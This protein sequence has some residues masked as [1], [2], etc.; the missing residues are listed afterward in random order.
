M[1][2]QIFHNYLT[3]CFSDETNN[4]VAIRFCNHTTSLCVISVLFVQINLYCIVSLM[5]GI[6]CAMSLPDYPSLQLKIDSF[7]LQT[8][9]NHAIR[10]KCSGLLVAFQMGRVV[11][12]QSS[13]CFPYFAWDES[14]FFFITY[15][16]WLHKL[17]TRPS[18][19]CTLIVKSLTKLAL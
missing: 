11:R 8:L 6:D 4:N 12:V 18:M 15:S 2:S 9:K 14:Y 10:T 13:G 19:I 7:A 16:I 5:Q 17:L 1:C 3:Y